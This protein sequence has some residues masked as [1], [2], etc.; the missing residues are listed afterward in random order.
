MTRHE[1]NYIAGD[2]L[3]G[4]EP[5]ANINPSDTSDIIGHYAQA[6]SAQLDDAL[7]A[8]RQAQKAWAAT[9][10]E[11]R[12]SVLM[13][14][15]N[16][17]MERAAELGELL[18]REEGKPLVEGK[19]EVFRAGQFFTY[20][21]AEVL[22]QLGENADSVRAGVEVDVRREPVGVVAII[23]PWN[24]PTATASWKIAPA[25][26]FGNA[27]LWKPANL[28]PASAVALTEIISR[29]DIPKGLFNLVM[30]TGHAVGQRLVESRAINAISFTGSVPVGRGIAAAAAPNFTKVQLE[31]GSKNAMVVMDDADLD[32]AVAHSLN[33]A[34]GGTGQKCTASSR[35]VVHEKVHDAFVERL[36]ASARDLRVGHA[37]HESTQIGPVASA[38]QLAENLDWVEKGRAEGAE[39]ACGGER[40]NRDTEGYYMAPGVFVNTTNAMQINREE[41]FAPLAAVIK[42]GSYGEALSV[43][44]DTRFGLTSGIMTRSLARASHFRRNAATGCV[45]VNLPTAGTDYHVPFGGRGESS[46]GPREQG[47]WAVDFYTTV[48]TTYSFAGSPE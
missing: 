14:I 34:F 47:R 10:L 23:S 6:T 3:D 46:Y 44:N 22:R 37:L 5:I 13:A 27:V 38:G 20:Y 41:M 39:L 29:Q 11:R 30:G 25:L 26:A 17:L 24:F 40:L 18:S 15:G 2:W 43:V 48:K 36:V 42:V 33:G 35:L 28:T 1:R 21:A 32:L 8:A 4:D 19:G 45:M 16:E 12:Q 9:G 31:M 7:E